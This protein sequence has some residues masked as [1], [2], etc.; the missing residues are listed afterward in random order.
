MVGEL[1]LTPAEHHK[2][3][4][5]EQLGSNAMGTACS[6]VGGSISPHEGTWGCPASVVQARRVPCQPHT[7]P[8][9][10]AGGG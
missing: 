2:F 7:A 10:P 9:T 6:E 4:A 8:R 3:K 5:I 1:G